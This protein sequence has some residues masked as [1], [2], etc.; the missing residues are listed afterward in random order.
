MRTAYPSCSIYGKYI[1]VLIHD[2]SHSRVCYLPSS[3]SRCSSRTCCMPID[4]WKNCLE[5][6]KFKPKDEESLKLK[7]DEIS[8]WASYRGQTLTRTGKFTNSCVLHELYLTC[9]LSALFLLCQWEEWCTTGGH[10]RFSVFKIKLILVRLIVSLL[11]YLHS[12]HVFLT[13]FSILQLN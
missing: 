12:L 1:L 4:E 7:M 8:P 3:V 11:L 6:I 5:R 2:L 9:C 10:L 13:P